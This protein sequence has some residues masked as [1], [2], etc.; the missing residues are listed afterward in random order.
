MAIENEALPS[1]EAHVW[2]R[3]TA[4]LGEGEVA[5]LIERLP[6][7]ERERCL[8]FRF[9]RDRRD[10]AAAHVL[11][12]T[13][14]SRYARTAASA[15]EFETG[16]YGKPSIGPAHRTDLTFNLSHTHG[17]VACAVTRSAAIGV[18]V[19]S[20]DRMPHAREIVRHYFSP[21]EVAALE[22][23]G[24]SEYPRRF[25]EVWTLKESYIKAI[26]LGLSHALDSFSFDI[27]VN[28]GIHF[29]PPPEDSDRKWQFHLSEPVTGFRL[30]LAVE[31]TH[32][33]ESC[34]VT[35]HDA[36]HAEDNV[37]SALS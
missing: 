36:E 29:T 26:G 15:W 12:R 22:H 8:R 35:F 1:G 10:F 11:I 9:A 5:E 6:P 2:F 13:T 17:L 27:A 25:I 33:F 32:G 24:P 14:L 16:A 21:S 18:D 7:S 37:R 28:G 23:L 30:A 4:H 19:E 20:V 34:K 3:S 31:R